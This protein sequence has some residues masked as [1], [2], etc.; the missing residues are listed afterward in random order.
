VLA[1]PSYSD[2][3]LAACQ[4]SWRAPP[5][6]S[7]TLRDDEMASAL[8]DAQF[9]ALMNG[10][11]SV[12]LLGVGPGALWFDPWHALLLDLW[13][14]KIPNF[15]GAILL[16]GS[17]DQ[18]RHE[19]V[20]DG[21]MSLHATALWENA[22]RSALAALAGQRVFV[23]HWGELLHNPD[24]STRA[25]LSFLDGCG[26]QHSVDSASLE[27]AFAGAVEMEAASAEDPEEQ[28]AITAFL[29]AQTGAHSDFASS[30]L[31]T[32]S[33]SAQELLTTQRALYRATAEG[34]EAW[35]MVDRIRREAT[36]SPAELAQ[37]L[38][39]VDS[40]VSHLLNLV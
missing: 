40:L 18:A 39:G 11:R 30:S 4:F 29:S 13:T 9:H 7:A 8:A 5:E 2:Q 19:L 34:A 33:H 3:I 15:G 23:C 38:A 28:A 20:R 32:L 1:T 25:L 35:R 24:K 16:W 10:M 21:V 37:A 31:G 14:E 6:H 36:T 27:L 12:D 17:P 26:L 22:A